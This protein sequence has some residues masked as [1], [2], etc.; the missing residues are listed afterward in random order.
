MRIVTNRHWAILCRG[1]RG[2]RGI[3]G[4]ILVERPDRIGLNPLLEGDL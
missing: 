3:A 2:E 1:G 4:M